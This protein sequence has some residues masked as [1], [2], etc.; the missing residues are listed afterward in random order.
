MFHYINIKII[1]KSYSGA[2]KK[3]THLYKSIILCNICTKNK[4]LYYPIGSIEKLIHFNAVENFITLLFFS[5][6]PHLPSS[7]LSLNIF[8]SSSLFP[9]IFHLPYSLPSSFIP[10][11]YILPSPHLPSSLS[12]ILLLF[13]PLLIE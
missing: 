3:Y 8:F 11:I 10:N 7:L 2:D 13:Y 6:F 4:T 9:L 12:F 1:I 5:P